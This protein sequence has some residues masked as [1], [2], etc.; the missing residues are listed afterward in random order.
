MSRNSTL[1]F[2]DL[3]FKDESLGSDR[4][5]NQVTFIEDLEPQKETINNI[6]TYAKSVKGVKTKSIDKILIFLN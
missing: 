1:K 3:I 2:W 4:F 5:S 6:L